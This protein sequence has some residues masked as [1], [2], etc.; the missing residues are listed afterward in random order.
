MIHWDS[1]SQTHT[2]KVRSR[3][4]DA[5][6]DRR[7]H[8]L[9]A[10]ADGMGGHQNGA[11]ASRMIVEQLADLPLGANLDQN[12]RRV[13]QALHQ[14]NHRLT[15]D[16]TL[17][18]GEPAPLIGSTVVAVATYGM[19]AVCLWAGDSRCYLWRR[20]KLYL[21]SKDHTLAQQLINGA[22]MNPAQAA[23]HP[24]AQALTRAVGAH[25]I[26]RLDV[27]EFNLQVGDRL[28]LCSDGL[29]RT[30]TVRQLNHALALP[31]AREA[32][33]HLFAEVL[34]GAA[35]DNLSA[36]VIRPTPSPSSP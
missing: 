1:A 31:S 16:L 22:N 34:Q 6:L 9:W 21:L 2:G 28:L 8:S 12:Q 23:Q 7:A 11:L 20:Q 30:L 35:S 33:E 19:R 14:V 24:S 27:T 32:V 18:A 4:E 3:N 17:C 36:I 26:L 25:E 10:V 13:R 5:V 29:Y 15:Q